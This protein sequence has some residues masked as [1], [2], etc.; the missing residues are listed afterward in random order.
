M[1]KIIMLFTVLTSASALA[2]QTHL[3]PNVPVGAQ[4]VSLFG[5]PLSMPVPSEKELENLAVAK[6][7]YDADPMDA[8]NTIW[9][10]RRVAYTGDFR[11]AI[12]IFSEGI[13]KHPMDARMYRHRGHRYITIREFDRAI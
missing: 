4:S 2:Q 6:A 12:L 8:D 3:L 13:R 10:G 7:E 5:E 9:Y 11:R 1:K